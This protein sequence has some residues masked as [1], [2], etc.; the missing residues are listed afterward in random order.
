MKYAY[1]SLDEDL[2]HREARHERRISRKITDDNEI[3]NKTDK[4]PLLY[5]GRL[6]SISPETLKIIIKREK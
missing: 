3:K 2:S 6:K 5:Q 4:L 1:E